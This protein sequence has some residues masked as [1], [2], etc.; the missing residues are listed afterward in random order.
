MFVT[1]DDED[2]KRFKDFHANDSKFTFNIQQN[3]RMD[4]SKTKRTTPIREQR[5]YDDIAHRWTGV[6]CSKWREGVNGLA[7]DN[8]RRPTR[9]INKREMDGWNLISV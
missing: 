3:P 4:V 8:Q 1:I 6:S 9:G 7:V 2:R 5:N